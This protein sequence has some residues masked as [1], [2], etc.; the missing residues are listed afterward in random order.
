MH[1]PRSMLLQA[2]A[3]KQR[4]WRGKVSERK[5]A[6]APKR[7]SEGDSEQEQE[8]AIKLLLGACWLILPGRINTWM[9]H[10]MHMHNPC[11]HNNVCCL[12]SKLYVALYSALFLWIKIEKKIINERCEMTNAGIL[13]SAAPSTTVRRMACLDGWEMHNKKKIT[14]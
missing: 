8:R 13:T 9:L 6:C 7:E 3:S 4:G 12:Y 1:L 10:F 14:G 2:G 11:R 5:R